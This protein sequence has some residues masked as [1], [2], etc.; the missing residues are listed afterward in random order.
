MPW[1]E[2]EEEIMRA[3]GAWRN[4]SMGRWAGRGAWGWLLMAVA[5]ALSACASRVDDA[6]ANSDESALAGGWHRGSYL[7]TYYTVAD[8]NRFK[9][10][11]EAVMQTAATDLV[12]V[13]TG[14]YRRDFLCSARGVATQGTG[15]AS[16]GRYIKY[17]S[18]AGPFSGTWFANCD[19]SD[20]RQM[21]VDHR[22]TGAAG[23]PLNEIVEPGEGS[24]AVDPSVIP[25]RSKVWIDELGKWFVAA[26]TGG[27]IKGAHIDVFVGRSG[28]TLGGY[29]SIYV[30]PAGTP[31]NAPPP[32]ASRTTPAPAPSPGG[33]A[34]GAI[35]PGEPCAT[36]GKIQGGVVCV[37]R[38]ALNAYIWRSHL[39]ATP[40]IP[41]GATCALQGNNASC[42]G[43]GPAQTGRTHVGTDSKRCFA[44][45]G[46][47]WVEM[48]G[49]GCY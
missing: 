21:P 43:G 41:C 8:E 9:A 32:N 7:L 24:I 6:D 16:D 23:I 31:T 40:F 35:A 36:P 19:G 34:S 18:G 42:S 22:V 46:Q 20:F 15:I 17:A 45:S 33:Q 25:L 49:W 11:L 27:A 44:C 47:G 10:G 14:S 2:M 30:A 4:A 28:R 37:Y 38:E 26:D 1:Q 12:R 48:Y 29:S 39:G 5:I 3:S 13:G